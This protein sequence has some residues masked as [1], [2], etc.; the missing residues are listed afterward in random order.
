MDIDEKGSLP[1]RKRWKM[2]DGSRS[3]EMSSAHPS[4]AL[5][6]MGTGWQLVILTLGVVLFAVLGPCTERKFTKSVEK[7]LQAI[8]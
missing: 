7:S 8:F 4:A 6:L 2:L 1:P 5:A 3:M